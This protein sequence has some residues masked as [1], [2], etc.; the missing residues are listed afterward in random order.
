MD[1]MTLCLIQQVSN[2][3]AKLEASSRGKSAYELAVDNGFSGT[4][5]E[6]LES[7][8]GIT[9]HIGTNNHWFIGNMDTGISAVPDLE[10]YYSKEN[11][12]AL[13]REE[14]LEICK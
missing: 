10:E 4:E 14:I 2:S 6:W 8:N 11:L 12:V 7:L 13:S 9:P 3:V 1:L 5:E